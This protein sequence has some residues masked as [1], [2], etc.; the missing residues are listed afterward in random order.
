[1]MKKMK[2]K[3][4]NGSVLFRYTDHNGLDIVRKKHDLI[5]NFPCDEIS[6]VKKIIYDRCCGNAR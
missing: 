5:F 3:E 4:K 2:K 1:M 6:C